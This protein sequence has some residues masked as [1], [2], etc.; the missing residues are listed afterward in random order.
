MEQTM[1]VRKRRWR[2]PSGE[3]KE[4]WVVDYVDQAGARHLKTFTLKREADAWHAIVAR[5]ARAGIHTPDSKSLTVAKAS[6]LWFESCEAAKLER[7]TL[8]SSCRIVLDKHILPLMGAVKISAMTVPM[9]R[10]FEDRLRADRSPA[11]VRKIVGMLGSVLADAQERGLVAQN[12]VRSLRGSR[13][14]DKDR[15]ADKRQKG[16]L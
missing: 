13:R 2:S 12:V 5:D 6:E 7:S 16:K 3:M 8:T 9:A 15:Y 14:R 1:S 4:T 10:A 11:M